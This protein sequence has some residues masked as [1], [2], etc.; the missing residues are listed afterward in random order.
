MFKFVLYRVAQIAIS[1]FIVITAVYFIF[2]IIPG[3]PT[4]A[5]VDGGFTVEAREMVI[6]RFGLDR[7]LHE[8]YFRYMRNVFQGDFGISFY[9]RR[10]ANVVIGARIINT[11]VLMIPAYLLAYVVG[12]LGGAFL[13]WRRGKALDN[14]FSAISLGFRSAPV[15]W[16]GMIALMIFA[17][18]LGWLP[19]S[20]MRSPGADYTNLFERFFSIDF[21]RHLTLPM[22]VMFLYTLAIPLLLMRN[23]MLGTFGEDYIYY[24]RA[25][26]LPE[27]KIIIKHS[28]RNALLPVVTSAALAIGT[29]VGG[30]IIIEYVFGWPGLGREI[31]F[32]TQRSDYP[33]AQFGLV[34][35]AGAVMTMN[36]IADVLYAYLDPR[37][38]VK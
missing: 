35:L 36:L 3:D 1:L 21:L 4:T 7:P 19:H 34:F 28:M 25:K 30:Q 2:R 14:I 27:W 33:V 13:S 5:F 17:Y 29:A 12:T 8:Q 10:P 37:V 38:R 9:Y 16:T 18:G 23:T 20:G 22:L 26:G 6:E 11:L 15:F 31:V 32:A 24:C